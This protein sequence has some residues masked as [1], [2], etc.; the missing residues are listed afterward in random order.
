MA[1]KSKVFAAG[2]TSRSSLK[3]GVE[4]VMWNP[5]KKIKILKVQIDRLEYQKNNLKVQIDE[6]DKELNNLKDDIGIVT[7]HDDQM[8]RD[9]RS[10]M[11]YSIKK[12]QEITRLQKLVAGLTFDA[13]AESKGQVVIL[14]ADNFIDINIGNLS[15]KDLLYG[16]QRL[17]LEA[18]KRVK[19]DVEGGEA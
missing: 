17:M 19:S 8:Q 14:F 3:E 11:D 4:Q 2:P 16:A 1:Q 5:W 18:L 10:C 7:R 9:I 12:D 6:K 15:N 13:D